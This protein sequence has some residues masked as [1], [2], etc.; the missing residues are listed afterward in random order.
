MT[1]KHPKADPRPHADHDTRALFAAQLRAARAALGWSQ[2][3]LGEKTGVTQRAIYKVENAATEPRQLTR[4]RIEKAFGDA[5]VEFESS[6]A[7]GFTMIVRSVAGDRP[8]AHPK[9][10]PHRRAAR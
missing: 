6:Q 1:Q 10:S 4:R 2:T 9:R 3:D 7:G 5:G 8:P